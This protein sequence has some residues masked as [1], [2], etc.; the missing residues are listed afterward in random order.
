M[1][2]TCRIREYSGI[3]TRRSTVRSSVVLLVVTVVV[4]VLVVVVVVSFPF[5]WL[6]FGKFVEFLFSFLVFH[7]VIQ[8][9]LREASVHTVVIVVLVLVIVLVVVVTIIAVLV[10]VSVVTICVVVLVLVVVTIF[11]VVLTSFRRGFAFVLT[12]FLQGI[13]IGLDEL[14]HLN[15]VLSGVVTRFTTVVWAKLELRDHVASETLVSLERGDGGAT[16]K[17]ERGASDPRIV[18][19]VVVVVVLELTGFSHE[20]LTHFGIGT[21]RSIE[22]DRGRSEGKG[23]DEKLHG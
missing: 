20:L 14:S 13:L 23:G 22:G 8:S 7:A 1:F 9:L 12:R 2:G 21:D 4:V 3:N 17:F 18:V 19:V 15:D 10:V 5:Q 16:I 11:A 6:T